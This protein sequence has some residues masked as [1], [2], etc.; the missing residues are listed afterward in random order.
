MSGKKLVVRIGRVD[1][2]RR[3]KQPCIGARLSQVSD[4]CADIVNAETTVAQ[5]V[6]PRGATSWR[7]RPK[8]AESSK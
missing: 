7:C 4:T 5:A 1:R 6:P 8:T 2:K 3:R